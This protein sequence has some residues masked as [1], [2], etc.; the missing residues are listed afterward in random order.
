V[1]VPAT[2][3][4]CSNRAPASSPSYSQPL[5]RRHVYPCYIYR[6]ICYAMVVTQLV[7]LLAK[8]GVTAFGMEQVGAEMTLVIN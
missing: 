4:S 6:F 2:R 7:D 5:T 8:R 3:Q 1:P